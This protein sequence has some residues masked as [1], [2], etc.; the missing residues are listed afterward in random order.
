MKAGHLTV[1]Y[2]VCAMVHFMREKVR[3]IVP[4]IEK[5]Y[6][7]IYAPSED[8]DQTAHAQSDQSLR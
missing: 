5:I 3:I 1:H 7:R 8:S 4:Q 2:N 6:L